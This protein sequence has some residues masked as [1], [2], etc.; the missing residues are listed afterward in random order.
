LPLFGL[1]QNAQPQ[2]IKQPV[3]Q[4][5]TT[6][7]GMQAKYNRWLRWTYLWTEND[8]AGIILAVVI[9]VKDYRRLPIVTPAKKVVLSRQRWKTETWKSHIIRSIDWHRCWWRR[10]TG[11]RLV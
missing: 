11:K 8:T 1:S 9:E 2:Y 4:D 5:S 7:T 10:M 3:T 6:S